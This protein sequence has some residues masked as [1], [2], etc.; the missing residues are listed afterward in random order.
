MKYIL[1]NCPVLSLSIL[2]AL[3]ACGGTDEIEHGLDGGTPLSADYYQDLC[4][5]LVFAEELCDG[6][7]MPEE[8]TA[9]AT[10]IANW[11]TFAAVGCS[12]AYAKTIECS[13]LLPPD[14]V[15]TESAEPCWGPL[16]VCAGE[17]C[18]DHPGH[19]ICE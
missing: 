15:C 12:D 14:A 6:D 3:A 5:D 17:Y 16:E 10:C 8:A 18:S 9:R 2:L 11:D 13:I 1:I 19:P 7:P 4:V